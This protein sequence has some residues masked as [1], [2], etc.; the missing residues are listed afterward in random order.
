MNKT[1]LISILD[2]TRLLNNL[3]ETLFMVNIAKTIDPKIIVEIG[4][5]RGAT[6]RLL[7]EVLSP[8]GVIIGI[9]DY[10]YSHNKIF[11]PDWDYEEHDKDVR[12]IYSD[13]HGQYAFNKLKTILNGRKI[14][15]LHIDGDHSYEGCKTD[16]EMYSPLVRNRGYIA[17]HD[18]SCDHVCDVVDYVSRRLDLVGEFVET[19]GYRIFS[20]KS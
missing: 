9:D 19:H 1:D 6:L 16:Y 4:V 17:F 5:Y 3:N 2:G 13:S 14:D 15:F 7:T 12:M 18:S 10:S 8:E 20:Y 11:G